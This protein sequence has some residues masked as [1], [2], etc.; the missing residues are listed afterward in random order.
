[1]SNSRSLV[2]CLSS[3][4]LLNNAGPDNIRAGVRL[5][6]LAAVFAFVVLASGFVPGTTT[7]ALAQESETQAPS[8]ININTA[9]ADT[10]ASTLKGV[11]DT[12]AQEIV[13]Y[14][15]QY[16]PFASVD[17]LTDVKGIGKSTLDDNRARITLE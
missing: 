3:T 14:R 9:D 5:S 4:P 8:S 6:A 12:R 13:R 2:R 7:A 1:M 17:E 10:I 11:G 15:E 16:G